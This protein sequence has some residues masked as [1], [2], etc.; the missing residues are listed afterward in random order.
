VGVVPNNLYNARMNA[1][2]MKLTAHMGSV[3]TAIEPTG[4]K[5]YFDSNIKN[6]L[7]K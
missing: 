6:P 1:T 3:V 5:K 2:N 4:K 7:A